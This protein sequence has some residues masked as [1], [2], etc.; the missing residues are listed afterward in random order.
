MKISHH[1][2]PGVLRR[3]KSLH[4]RIP[5]EVYLN[6]R[7]FLVTLLTCNKDGST[8]SFTKTL[9]SFILDTEKKTQT[10]FP[11]TFETVSVVWLMLCCAIVVTFNNTNQNNPRE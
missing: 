3:Q 1:F 5:F 10:A 4:R 9:V 7:P 8:D 11:L 6:K 2:A